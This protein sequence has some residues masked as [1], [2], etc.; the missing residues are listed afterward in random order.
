GTGRVAAHLTNAGFEV[1]GLDTSEHMLECARTKVGA[2]GA[3]WLSLNDMRAFELG[4]TFELVI[5]AFGT[6]HLLLT[7]EDQ[8]ACLRCVRDHLTPGGLFAFDLR[9][10]WFAAWD[11]GTSVPLQHEWSRTL[12]ST[13]ETVTKLASSR[14]DPAAQLQHETHIYD[15]LGT[16]GVLRRTVATVDSRFSTRYEIEGLLTST[17]LELDQM[18]GDFELSP[19][20]ETSEYMITIA[21]KAA[22]A[23]E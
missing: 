8:L 3:N 6:F 23:P 9:P 1:W 17:G 5:A 13:G 21:R 10:W 22:E 20:D 14:A 4:R 18:Y 12:P 11:E 15:R 19:F 7:P 16:D 2:S